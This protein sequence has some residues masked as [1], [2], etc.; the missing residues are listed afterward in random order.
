[1]LVLDG[2]AVLLTD[3]FGVE[4]LRLC[5]GLLGLMQVVSNLVGLFV[6]GAVID[7]IGSF[8]WFDINHLY[9]SHISYI[10]TRF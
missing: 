8:Y 1:M 7:D 9:K 10:K 6:A 4:T 5:F 2:P 3:Y